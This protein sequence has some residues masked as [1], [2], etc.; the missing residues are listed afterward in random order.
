M[1]PNLNVSTC[2]GYF[3]FVS[4]LGI[5]ILLCL[6]ASILNIVSCVSSARLLQSV[7]DCTTVSYIPPI[8][9]SV[10]TVSALIPMRPELG[11]LLSLALKQS[12]KA[13][14]LQNRAMRFIL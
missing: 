6:S 11:K 8:G 5:Q 12:F 4:R 9:N 2:S 1:G 13:L 3:F 10:Q 14:K 7:T